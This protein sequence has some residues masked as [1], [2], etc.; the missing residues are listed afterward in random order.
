M[1]NFHFHQPGIKWAL[2]E[3]NIQGNQVFGKSKKSGQTVLG[4][5]LRQLGNFA[6]GKEFWYLNG[7]YGTLSFF[8]DYQDGGALLT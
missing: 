1:P 8:A 5:G 7:K 6:L 3:I 2:L 4:K